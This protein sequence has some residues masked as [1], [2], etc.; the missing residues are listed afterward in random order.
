MQGMEVV[1]DTSHQRT[2]YEHGPQDDLGGRYL[3]SR[4]FTILRMILFQRQYPDN[5]EIQGCIEMNHVIPSSVHR[6]LVQRNVPN[7]SSRSK[8]PD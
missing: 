2:G 7:H 8:V 3:Q 5:N 6:L 1:S 4:N